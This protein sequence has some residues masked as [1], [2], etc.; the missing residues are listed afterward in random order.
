MAAVVSISVAVVVVTVL[1]V[2]VA[3]TSRSVESSNEDY[4]VSRIGH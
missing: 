3:T 1:V 2:T 4:S